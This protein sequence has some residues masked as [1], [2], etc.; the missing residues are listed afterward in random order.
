MRKTISFACVLAFALAIW[1]AT[2]TEAASRCYP[3][4]RFV[5]LAGGLVR[6]TLT[7]LVWQQQASTT[8][9]TLAAAQTYCPSGFRLPTVK[10][11]VSI[12][13]LTVVA[14]GPTIDKTA[15]PNTPAEPFWTCTSNL[16]TSHWFVNFADGSYDWNL[17]NAIPRVRCVR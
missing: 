4:K 13:D 17:L 11:L 3:T 16:G 15:F 5:V 2:R 12:V 10:E 1:S 8:T 6:D 7:S 9:M 14:P